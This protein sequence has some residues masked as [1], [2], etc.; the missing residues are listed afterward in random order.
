MWCNRRLTCYHITRS[1]I[2]DHLRSSKKTPNTLDGHLLGNIEASDR[3]VESRNT[4]D[5][6]NDRNT[7]INS[8]LDVIR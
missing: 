6:S 5:S 4:S 3:L 1:K 8:A 7:L 2:I